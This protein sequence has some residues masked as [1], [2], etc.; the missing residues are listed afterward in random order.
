MAGLIQ[1]EEHGGWALPMMQVIV[2]LAALD[3]P[4]SA[5]GLRG[6]PPSAIVYAAPEFICGVSD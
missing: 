6:I 3:Q 4:Q 2:F 1:R 5:S